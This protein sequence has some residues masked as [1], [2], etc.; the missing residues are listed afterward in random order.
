M[1]L[2]LKSFYLFI[3]TVFSNSLVRILINH[4]EQVSVSPAKSIRLLVVRVLGPYG[5]RLRLILSGDNF[6]VE[7]LEVVSS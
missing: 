1:W 5:V 3:S 2:S 6:S 7:V 4:G